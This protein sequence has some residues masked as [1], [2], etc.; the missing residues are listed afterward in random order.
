LNAP[1]ESERGRTSE[2]ARERLVA[3][4]TGDGADEIAG[5]VEPERLERRVAADIATGVNR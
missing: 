3:R 5:Y 2:L 1:I 4:C